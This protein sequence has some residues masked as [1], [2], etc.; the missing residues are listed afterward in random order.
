MDMMTGLQP[1]E[2]CSESFPVL[3][4]AVCSAVVVVRRP[5][6]M[7]RMMGPR[8]RSINLAATSL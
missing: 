5:C 2:E 4:V 7:L 3:I 6:L 1:I 8:A